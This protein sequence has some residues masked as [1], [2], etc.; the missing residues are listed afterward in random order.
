MTDLQETLCGSVLVQDSDLERRGKD[1]DG[2]V[3]VE[4][5]KVGEECEMPG[6]WD[7]LGSVRNSEDSGL[8]HVPITQGEP[9]IIDSMSPHD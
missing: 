9:S 8:E 1:A 6:I 5:E 7:D 4:G 2:V 3:H